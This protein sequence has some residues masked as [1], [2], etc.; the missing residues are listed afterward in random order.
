MIM[1]NLFEMTQAASLLYDLL[2]NDEIDEQTVN[3]TLDAMGT[4]EKVES[5]CKVIKQLQA[6]TEMFKAEIDRISA[7]KR[8]AENAIERMRNALL[9]FMEAS[10]K[11]KIT[12]GTFT[13]STATTK[14]VNIVDESLIPSEYLILPPVKID[15]AE[16]SKALRSGETVKGAELIET[17]GVRIR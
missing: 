4:D 17:K 12:A 13:V 15:K 8:T 7:R 1:A 11:D 9:A 3:D 10:K 16:I 5:Y 14:S 2:Q 6:D